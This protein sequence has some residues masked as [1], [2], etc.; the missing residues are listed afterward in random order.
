MSRS[1][2]GNRRA[3]TFDKELEL[4]SIKLA[5]ISATTNQTA[6]AFPATKQLDFKAV[7]QV[8]T[9]T[10][11]VAG[12]AEWT[13]EVQA[14]ADNATFKR[15]GNPVTPAGSIVNFEIALSGRSI[16]NIVPDA[17]YVRVI[18]TKTGSPGNLTYGAFLT[19]SH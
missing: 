3:I 12:T 19:T 8:A 6:I 2:I 11:Y 17:A 16:E 18:A 13:I 14:S 7:I 15:V 5:A 10:G 4:R 9:H 1:S